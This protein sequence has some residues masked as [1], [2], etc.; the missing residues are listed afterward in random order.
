MAGRGSVVTKLGVAWPL[1]LLM[2]LGSFGLAA[3]GEEKEEP[4]GLVNCEAGAPEEWDSCYEFF[5]KFVECTAEETR[6]YYAQ[7]RF[8]LAELPKWALT[9]ERGG[10]PIIYDVRAT[11]APL[12]PGDAAGRLFEWAERQ[13]LRIN[14]NAMTR[15]AESMTEAQMREA[16]GGGSG[17]TEWGA[18]GAS[19]K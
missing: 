14:D 7:G 9:R 11:D 15:C 18:G 5:E 17:T 3:C 8:T 10:A 4:S 6:E 16:V 1:T 12:G 13:G 2:V 19:P